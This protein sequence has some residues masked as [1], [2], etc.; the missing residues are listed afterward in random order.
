MKKIFGLFVMMMVAFT[1]N[2]LYAQTSIVVES[3]DKQFTRGTANAY[4]VLVPEGKLK[5]VRESY[6]GFIKSQ[7]KAKTDE[8]SGELVSSECKN[9]NIHDVPF[10]I[11]TRLLETKDGVQ[12]SSFFW[13]YDTVYIS[14]VQNN[15]KDQ[16]VMKFMRDLGV[17]AYTDVVKKQLDAESKKLKDLENQLNDLRK[18]EEKAQR[19]IGEKERE[20][21]RTNGSIEQNKR[22][23]ETKLNEIASHKSST[24]A[25]TGD[26]KK[27]ADK[28]LKELNGEKK[29]LEK[30]NEKMYK[31][32]DKCKSE[33]ST[34]QVNVAKYKKEQEM[35]AAE[36]ENQRATTNNIDLKLKGI[37]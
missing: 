20:I 37:K 19:K 29:G 34:E 35:K 24:A 14:K 23:Q 33:I 31:D 2:S 18:E 9:S 8:L 17:S 11:I 15:D 3:G 30:A 36:V 22:D 32:I 16:A 28:K 10:T 1:A 4:T 7:C 27:A 25:L 5:D 26:M 12:I 6:E 13:L 21:E